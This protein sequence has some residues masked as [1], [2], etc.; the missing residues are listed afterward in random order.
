MAGKARSASEVKSE[1]IG[2]LIVTRER[3]LCQAPANSPGYCGIP[4]ARELY[5]PRVTASLPWWRRIG[6]AFGLFFRILFD[7]RF[8]QA[9]SRLN[10]AEA[11]P[12]AGAAEPA[13]A[14]LPQSPDAPALV[15]LSL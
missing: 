10:P 13:P 3:P 12:T 7:A 14:A 8:A 9:A 1:P 2:A 11:E 6:L 15:L 4:R 5:N